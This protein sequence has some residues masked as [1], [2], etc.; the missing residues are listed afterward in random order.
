MTPYSESDPLLL[1]DE[2][3]Q[4]MIQMLVRSA[5]PLLG[6]E[7]TKERMGVSCTLRFPT[8]GELM[9]LCPQLFLVSKKVTRTREHQFFC[10]GAI[11][12]EWFLIDVDQ[13]DESP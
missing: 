5:A 10:G 6:S 2:L 13:L 8:L 3:A 7:R 9:H 1:C 12:R 4:V 11:P